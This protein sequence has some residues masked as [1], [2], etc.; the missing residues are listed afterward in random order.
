MDRKDDG[1]FSMGF[2]AAIACALAFA[3]GYMVRDLGFQFRV[4]QPTVEQHR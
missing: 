1:S 3:T 4:Q 2:V